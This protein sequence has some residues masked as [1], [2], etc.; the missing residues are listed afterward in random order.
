MITSPTDLFALACKPE[1]ELIATIRRGL[2]VRVFTNLARAL[3]MPESTLARHLHISYRTIQRKRTHGGLLSPEISEKIIRVA[4]VRDLAGTLFTSDDAIID[5]L[6]T[7]K[8]PAL[9]G[10][11]PIAWMDTATGARQ[12]EALLLGI[13]HGN[14]M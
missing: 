14:V 1:L 12:V 11:P 3:K 4:R 13:I 2:P 5:W 9:H 6:T 8:A 7:T 10:V